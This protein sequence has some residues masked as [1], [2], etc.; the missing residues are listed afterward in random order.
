M[1]MRAAGRDPRNG[2]REHVSHARTDVRT[3]EPFGD[4][5]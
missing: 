1:I 2:A 3:D 4:V 5:V